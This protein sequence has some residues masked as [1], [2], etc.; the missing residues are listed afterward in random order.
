MKKILKIC[1]FLL[2]CGLFIPIS[3]HPN[4]KKIGTYHGAKTTTHPLWFKESFLNFEEDVD[5]AAENNK[6]LALYFWQP[7]CPYCNQLWEENFSNPEIV[8]K[9]QNNFEIV[10]M[11]IWGD[12]EV[13]SVEGNHYTEKSFAAAL[14]IAYTPTLLFF[15]EEK[16][17]VHRLNGYIPAEEFQLSMQYVAEKKEDSLTF[18]KYA[19]LSKQQRTAIAK[20]TSKK[21]ITEDFF[22]TTLDTTHINLNQK[23]KIE[24]AYLAV[25]FEA[26]DCENCELLHN[27]TLADMTT[28][29]LARKF[30]SIQL[31]RFSKTPITTPT[32]EQLSVKDWADELNIPYLPS[33]IFFN[34]RGQE[35]MRVDTQ[36]RTFHIQSVFDYVMSGA[37]KTEQNF[38]R[39]ISA[40]A[41]KI[42]ET[43]KDVDIFAY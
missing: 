17:I 38:Q 14:K 36:L 6:R 40:R 42:R 23:A 2:L 26:T 15:N 10:A 21:L 3:I 13:V 7:G 30:T 1:S 25:Y 8:K 43:G 4:E 18:G 24:G 12:R 33:I 19:A 35:I 31:D 28:R 34:H 27:K 29:E 9:F 37:Y 20:N 16:K 41:D 5:E 22:D 32:G 11:N 39:Y